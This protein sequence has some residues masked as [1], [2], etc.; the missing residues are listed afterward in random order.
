MSFLNLQLR[1]REREEGRAKESGKLEGEGGRTWEVGE[2]FF[3]VF[4][5]DSPLSP[6]ESLS[7]FSSLFSSRCVNVAELSFL[8]SSLSRRL[9]ASPVKPL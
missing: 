9:C 1:E 4:L 2:F 5:F 7:F 6:L 8:G 3:F